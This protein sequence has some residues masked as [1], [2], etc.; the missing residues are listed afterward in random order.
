MANSNELG[1]DEAIKM[2]NDNILGA[3]S[4][5]SMHMLTVM[6]LTGNCVNREFLRRATLSEAC[7]K[8][9]RDHLFPG[10][11][12]S[13][14]QMKTALN[15]VVRKLGLTEFLVENLLCEALRPKQ[16]YDTYHPSQCIY[17]LERDTDNILRVDS[18]GNVQEVRSEAD[19]RKALD[20][21]PDVDQIVPRYQWWN[22]KLG[23]EG[24]HKWYIHICM[25]RNEPLQSTVMRLHL[26]S[27]KKETDAMVWNSYI[28]Q[29]GDDRKSKKLSILQMEKP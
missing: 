3:G 16:G 28:H 2:I 18:S 4:L 1:F 12:V 29:L 21:L 10:I 9:V 20:G 8:H 22:A 19:D 6:T 11:D 14:Q 24:I 25:E 7:K 17:F 27:K 26:N 13:M 5:T 23:M 15:R